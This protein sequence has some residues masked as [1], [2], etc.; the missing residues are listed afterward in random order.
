MEIDLK[1][2]RREQI[3]WLILVTLKAAQPVGANEALVLDVLNG[4]K[5]QV[6]LHELREELDYLEQRELLRISEQDSPLW[7]AKLTRTG[8]DVAE[9]TVEC[10]PGIARPKKYFNV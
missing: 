3:R 2:A 9:Y 4:A 7:F 1:K 5:M 6:T 10:D 8:I